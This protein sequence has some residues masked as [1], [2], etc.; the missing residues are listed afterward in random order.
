MGLWTQ[1]NRANLASVRTV[2]TGI[3]DVQAFPDCSVSL[4]LQVR[5]VSMV[6]VTHRPATSRQ[7][8][9]SSLWMWKDPQ[10]TDSPTGRER[11]TELDG[12]S[13]SELATFFSECSQL[14]FQG[15]VHP[16]TSSHISIRRGQASSHKE[17]HKKRGF[18][19]ARQ[20]SNLVYFC[21][22]ELLSENP[23]PISGG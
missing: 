20:K 7:G 18:S 15:P 12:I 5:T 1:A 16:L 3:G 10:G 9:L 19:W 2:E 4:V 11:E 22:W 6:T 23:T 21:T 17:T 14:V 8:P 13:S